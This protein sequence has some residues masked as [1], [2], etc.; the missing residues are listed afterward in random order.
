MRI[1]AGSLGLSSNFV[2]RNWKGLGG[3]VLADHKS[4]EAA[5]EN[6]RRRHCPLVT[7]ALKPNEQLLLRIIPVLDLGT[8]FTR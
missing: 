1:C 8:I 6:E 7:G 4:I 2:Q 3:V 5:V